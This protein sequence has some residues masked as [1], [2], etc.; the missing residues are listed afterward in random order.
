MKK[1]AIIGAGISGLVFANFLRQNSE[2][3][4]IIYEKN[5]SINLEKAYGIQLSV[6]SIKLLNK[7]GF[8]NINFGFEVGKRG[9][10]NAGL[11]K[12][13]FFSVRLGLTLNDRWFVKNKYN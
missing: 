11:I 5:N 8:Q 12:E 7:I 9:T 1:I 13:K 6:N 3:E 10:T 2:Y 4:V